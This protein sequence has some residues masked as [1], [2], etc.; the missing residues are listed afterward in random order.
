MIGHSFDYDVYEYEDKLSQFTRMKTAQFTVENF[1]LEE[2]NYYVLVRH[3]PRT[4]ETIC[5]IFIV[6]DMMIT[7]QH[8]KCRI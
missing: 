3:I 7:K 8:I 2:D 5:L 1:T 6:T 4:K